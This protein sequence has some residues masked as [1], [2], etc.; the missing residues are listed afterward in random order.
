MTVK[1]DVA[2][3]DAEQAPPAKTRKAV[4]IA[5]AKRLLVVAVLAGATWSLVGQWDEVSARLLALPWQSVVLSLVAVFVGIF[6]GPLVWKIVL[7]DLGAPVRFVDASKFYL[8][9]QL[10]KYVPG[11]VWAVLLSMELAREAGVNRARSFT[12]GLVATGMGV[13]ASL[14]AGLAALPVMLSGR[15]ESNQLL[16]LF[17]LLAV[18][19]PF[20]HPK[21]LTWS[22]NLVLKTLRKAPID[23]RFTGVEILKALGTAVAIYLCYGVHLWLLVN[24]LGSPR[25]DTLILSTGAMALSMTAGLLAFFLPSGLGAREL[26]ITGTIATVLPLPDAIALALVSRLMFTIADLVSAGAA[27]LLAYVQKKRGAPVPVP[28]ED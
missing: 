12:A 20:L 2:P 28:A 7:S 16:W 11:A 1:S 22:V 25:W 5:W 15:P 6:L 14:I 24:S 10:G 21:L 17:L 27:A 4:V 9:G 3:A 19:L 23:R 18:G 26:V 13:L 8:V